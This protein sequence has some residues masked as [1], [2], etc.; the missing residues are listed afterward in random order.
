MDDFDEDDFEDEDDLDDDED[1]DDDD[2]EEEDDD[3]VSKLDFGCNE[4]VLL[5]I[6]YRRTVQGL[7][8]RLP[9]ASR[10]KLHDPE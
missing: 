5:T 4:P 6:C 1:R 3:E 8:R 2:E 7:S 9:S 10:A